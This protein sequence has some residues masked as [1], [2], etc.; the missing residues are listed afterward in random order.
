MDIHKRIKGGKAEIASSGYT[1]LYKSHLTVGWQ[2]I[3]IIILYVL[4]NNATPKGK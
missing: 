1:T 2:M 4:H 3:K